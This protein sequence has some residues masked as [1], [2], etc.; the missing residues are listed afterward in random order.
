MLGNGDLGKKESRPLFCE[1]QR[2]RKDLRPL[3]AMWRPAG[4]RLPTPFPDPIAGEPCGGEVECWGTATSGKKSPDPFFVRSNAKE[5]TYDPCPR[6]GDLREK[7][8]RPLFRIRLPGN[9]AAVR[10]NA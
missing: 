3:S 5:R 6:C 10:S 8:S 2:E 9:L 7:D 4:E 1:V